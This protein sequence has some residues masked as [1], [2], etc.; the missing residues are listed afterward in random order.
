MNNADWTAD[1]LREAENVLGYSF[2]DKEL[3]KKAFTHPT[4]KNVH[5]GE[6]NDRLEFLGDAVLQICVSEKIFS[7]D[8]LNAG[9]LTDLR[10]QYVSQEALTQAEERAGLMRFLRY[11]GRSDNLDGKTNSNL[12]EAVT[13]AIYLDGG[14]AAAEKFIFSYLQPVQSRN[15][16]QELQEFVQAKNK[17]TPDYTPEGEENGIFYFRVTALGKS[18]NGSGTN[19]QAAKTQAAERLLAILQSEDKL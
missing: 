9:R 6:D 10:K 7:Q 12:F 1:T 13:A 18:A 19:K 4:Y 14:R 11:E 17:K 15:Y 5:G 8:D 3:L 2:R 16:R